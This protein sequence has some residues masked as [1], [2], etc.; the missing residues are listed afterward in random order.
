MAANGPFCHGAM[1]RNR[2]R[3][4]AAVRLSR[5]IRRV[6][7]STSKERI[8]RTKFL[9]AAAMAALLTVSSTAVALAQVADLNGQYNQD[10]ISDLNQASR[11][12]IPGAAW[13]STPNAGFSAH[14]H[15]HYPR[16]R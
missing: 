6:T 15:P 11:M 7:S 5:Y 9:T 10:Q 3:G 16:H 8:M 13:N 1:L 14:H 12:P 2:G 4:Q